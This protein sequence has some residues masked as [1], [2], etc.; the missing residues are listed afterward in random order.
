[1]KKR[2]PHGSVVKIVDYLI[3]KS[4]SNHDIINDKAHIKCALNKL[5]KINKEYNTLEKIKENL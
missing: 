1:M 2:T 5:S 3:V 4:A